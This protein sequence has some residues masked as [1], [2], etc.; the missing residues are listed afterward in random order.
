VNVNGVSQTTGGNLFLSN[1]NITRT[2]FAGGVFAQPSNIGN[3]DRDRLGA[4]LDETLNFRFR[5]LPRLSLVVGYN[6]LLASSVARPSDSLDRS[7]NAT[8]TGLAS[9]VRAAGSPVPVSGMQA[10]VFTFH[11]SWFWAQ[12]ITAG[13]EVRY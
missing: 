7:I 11:D 6:F 3:H 1:P 2:P 12:S 4:V 8:Q 9:A 10:P 13:V 5:V